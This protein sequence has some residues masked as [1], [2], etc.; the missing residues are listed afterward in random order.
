M[1]INRNHIILLFFIISGFLLRYLSI[2]N[3]DLWYDEILTFSLTSNQISFSE[4]YF[5]S[6]E[7]EG[8]PYLFNFF[9]RF[10]FKIFL[11]DIYIVKVFLVVISTACIISTSYLTYIITKDNSYVLAA[12]LVSFNVFLLEYSSELRVYTFLYFFSTL[13]IIFFIKYL[14]KKNIQRLF[15]FS[16]FTLIN[17]FLHPFSLLIF[18]SFIIYL[19]LL[20]IQKKIIYEKLNISLILLLVLNFLYYFYFYLNS[21]NIRDEGWIQNVDIDF[22]YHYFFANFFGSRILGVTFLIL[23]VYLLFKK[24]TIK[25]NYPFFFLILFLFSYILPLVFSYL[26]KPILIPRYI[27]FVIISIIILVSSLLF[28]LENTNLKKALIILIYTIISLNTFYENNF[29]KIFHKNYLEKPQFT[30][31]IETIGDSEYKSYMIKFS[32]VISD[33]KK[34]TLRI[35]DLYIQHLSSIL[36]IRIKYISEKNI[37]NTDKNFFWIICDPI[38]NRFDCSV[39]K[40]LKV[41]LLEDFNFFKINLKLVEKI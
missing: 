31:T 10:F 21:E 32:H 34:S 30:K 40:N 17:S 24:F 2:G 33:K 36:D 39:P 20:F 41:K 12:F 13:S 3:N 18:F 35:Y 11:Y 26:I 38:I 15:F 23:M 19:S 22:Y 9:L 27:I 4:S 25:E 14:D 1:S 37:L 29:K 28:K 7:L 5:L 6:N 16:F 8:T